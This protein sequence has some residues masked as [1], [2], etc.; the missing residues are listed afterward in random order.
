MILAQLLENFDKDVSAHTTI[1]IK[2]ILVVLLVIILRAFLVQR[3][4]L[5]A[6]R[7][8]A[9]G[10]FVVLLL[11][12]IYPD[13]SNSLAHAVGVGRGVDLL[14]YMSNLFLLLLI[15]G[16]WRRLNILNSSITRLSRSIAIQTARKPA[17][18][19]QTDDK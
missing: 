19:K 8:S 14:F 5:I 13:V 9:L 2:V 6:K 4:L 16:Q 10:M 11:L 15:V 12:V 3:Q 18:N 7:L 1:W 17:D